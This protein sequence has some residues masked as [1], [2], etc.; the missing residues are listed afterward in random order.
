MTPD[1]YG[2]C[3]AV[4]RDEDMGW[5]VGVVERRVGVPTVQASRLALVAIALTGNV[6]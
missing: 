4:A 2:R 5:V 1:V 6:R 3:R